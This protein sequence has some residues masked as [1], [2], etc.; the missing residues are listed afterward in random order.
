MHNLRNL[1]SA[2]DLSSLRTNSSQVNFDRLAD[3][4][5]KVL[6]MKLEDPEEQEDLLRLTKSFLS[7][8]F[9]DEQ[10]VGSDEI[11][12]RQIRWS[13]DRISTLKDLASP[14]VSFL[15]VSP[16]TISEDFPLSIDIIP[17]IAESLKEIDD[18][19]FSSASTSRALRIFS[20]SSKCK[21]AV[22]MKSVRMLLSGLNDGPPVGEMLEL[23]G[24]QQ[25]LKRIQAGYELLKK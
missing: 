22:L 6:E 11:L 1:V 10:V 8:H 12:L 9:K 15:F 4:N 20:K 2:F 7:E 13:R 14:S 23:L 25:S 3:L 21:F 17:G 5:K 18:L 16:S 24:K 19:E